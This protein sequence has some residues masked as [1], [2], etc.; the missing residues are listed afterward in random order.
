ML[1]SRKKSLNMSPKLGWKNR[2]IEK[3]CS[4]GPKCG[5]KSF[6]VIIYYQLMIQT[7]IVYKIHIKSTFLKFLIFI[8][9][10]ALVVGR[11]AG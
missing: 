8:F 11:P 6:S 4:S 7:T 2:K 3:K 5:K 1:N 10:I 9:T